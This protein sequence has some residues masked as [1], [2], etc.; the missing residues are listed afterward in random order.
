MTVH[1]SWCYLGGN[2]QLQMITNDFFYNNVL[3]STEISRSLKVFPNILQSHRGSCSTKQ[4]SNLTAFLILKY[5][6]DLK[7]VY[8]CCKMKQIYPILL[9]VLKIKA[10][11][12]TFPKAVSSLYVQDK[13]TLKVSNSNWKLHLVLYVAL[14][15]NVKMP[16]QKS[17]SEAPLKWLI[18]KIFWFSK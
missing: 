16:A 10:N 11:N 14:S 13:I 7:S 12:S 15:N 1:I 18:F 6:R 9:S 3:Y 17:T 8:I 5:F 2:Q 4:K